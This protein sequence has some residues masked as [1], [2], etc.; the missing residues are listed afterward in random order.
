MSN[1]FVQTSV[2]LKE[3]LL[4]AYEDLRSRILGRAGGSWAG[5]GLAVIVRQCMAAWM[6]A[7][8]Q[9]AAF[10]SERVHEQCRSDLALPLDLRAEA[11]RILAAMAVGSLQEV[12]R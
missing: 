6:E 2:A 8:S 5:V 11:T 12:R 9:P 10:V 1:S 3:N 4:A 7:L